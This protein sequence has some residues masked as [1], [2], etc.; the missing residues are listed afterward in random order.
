MRI[1]AIYRSALSYMRIDSN[2][3]SEAGYD[4]NWIDQYNIVPFYDTPSD[5]RFC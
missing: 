4:H 5:L 1:M 2:Q 3:M